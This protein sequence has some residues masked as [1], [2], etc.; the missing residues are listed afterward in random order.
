[1]VQ[2]HLRE[3]RGSRHLT[4]SS[5]DGR[6]GDRGVT[7]SH[8][9]RGVGADEL[10]VNPPGLGRLFGG[11]GL[12]VVLTGQ[13]EGDVLLA[14]L[15]DQEGSE[16]AEPVWGT[17]G[18]LWLE[19]CV[20]GGRRGRRRGLT[21]AGQQLVEGLLP[22]QRFVVAQPVRSRKPVRKLK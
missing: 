20:W 1:M 21:L 12:L 9:S 3:E 22:G 18:R 6:P 5:G 13:V 2:V 15:G 16:E 7:G 4:P 8:L 11:L 10:L 14:E 17:G 19:V